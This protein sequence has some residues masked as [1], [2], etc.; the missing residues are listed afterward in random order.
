MLMW[1]KLSVNLEQYIHQKKTIARLQPRQRIRCAKCLQHN[2]WCYCSKLNPIN[3][4]IEFVILLHP[5]ERRRRI[6]S[7]RMSYLMLKESHLAMGHTFTDDRKV[8][9]LLQNPKYYPVILCLGE[10]SKN[11]NQISEHEKRNLCPPGKK[12]LIFVVD[13]TWGTASKTVRLS[14]NLFK[15]PRISFTPPH[16]STFRVRQQPKKECFSTIEA[17]HQTIELLGESQGF[18]VKS[19]KHDELLRVFDVFVTQ[20]VEY[21]KDLKARLGSLQYRSKA[22][23]VPPGQK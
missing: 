19:R 21:L 2:E 1:Y 14:K 4:G 7:G 20:Q 8:N 13:G 18:D 5:L 17:I 16:A 10:H 23:R 3:C 6:A 15:L 12:L 9:E 11:L 22:V